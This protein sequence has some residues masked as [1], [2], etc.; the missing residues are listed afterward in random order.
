MVLGAIM[1]L[2][3][4]MGS[5]VGGAA[6]GLAQGV[7]GAA[8][9]IAGGIG[10]AVGGMAQGA[11]DLFGGVGGPQELPIS[12]QATGSG[13]TSA[14]GVQ[15]PTPSGGQDFFSEVV[16]FGLEKL[17]KT[18]IGEKLTGAGLG[19]KGLDEVGK[20]L[21]FESIFSDSGGGD[22]K[23]PDQQPAPVAVAPKLAPQQQTRKPQAPQKTDRISQILAQQKMLRNQLKQGRI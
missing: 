8:S 19:E 3:S 11:G 10:D 9:G 5:A 16:G 22:K 1:G 12:M 20:N 13:K 15:P 14:L 18:P 6:G 21:L 2:L 4:S 17:K 7:G 23:Q